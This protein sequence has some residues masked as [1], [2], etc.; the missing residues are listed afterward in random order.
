MTTKNTLSAL[1]LEIAGESHGMAHALHYPDREARND[2]K[3]YLADRIQRRLAPLLA[4]NAKLREAQPVEA[5]EIIELKDTRRSMRTEIARLRGALERIAGHNR[6][7]AEGVD[8][9]A[10]ALEQVARKAL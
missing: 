2:A 1:A 10:G 8:R 3:A 5:S 4:E 9:D 6:G 7:A